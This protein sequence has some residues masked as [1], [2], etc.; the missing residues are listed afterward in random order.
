MPVPHNLFFDAGAL[1]QQ[2][3]EDGHGQRPDLHGMTFNPMPPAAHDGSASA[4][5]IRYRATRAAWTYDPDSGLYLRSADGQPHFGA[6]TG[7][8]ISAANVVVLFTP[9]RLTDIEESRYG[10]NVTYGLE[11]L[12]NDR[13]S[14]LLFRD[15]IVVAGEWHSPDTEDIPTLTTFD[16]TLLPLKPGITWYQVVRP[17]DAMQPEE[18]WVRWEP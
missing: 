1:W 7:I 11:I 4:I 10:D 5:D 3:A 2:A 16:G 17:V 14:A 9:H 12:F 13:G 15:G 6:G 8:Q 18:E